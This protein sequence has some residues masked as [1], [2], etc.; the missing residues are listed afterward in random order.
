VRHLDPRGPEIAADRRDVGDQ[1]VALAAIAEQRQEI[2]HQSEHRLDHPGQV[3]DGDEG[4]DL[5]RRPAVHVLE[6]IGER[7]RDQ[8]ADLAEALHHVD[9]AEEQKEPP[10][11][12]PFAVAAVGRHERAPVR[13]R[14]RCGLRSRLR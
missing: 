2:G 8:P 13:R 4:G 5:Q 7:L 11:H 1:Q 14:G 3:E 12:R 9:E 6:I 10:D